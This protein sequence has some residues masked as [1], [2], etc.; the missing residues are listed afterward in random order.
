MSQDA[1]FQTNPLFVDSKILLQKH[2]P[3]AGRLVPHDPRITRRASRKYSDK[4]LIFPV[5]MD[6]VEASIW[7]L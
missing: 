4:V 1:R 6:G 7:A 3:A 5:L 2:F